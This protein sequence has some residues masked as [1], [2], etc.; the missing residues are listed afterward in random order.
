MPETDLFGVAFGLSGSIEWASRF[1]HD[2]QSVLSGYRETADTHRRFG[3]FKF[4][5]WKFV[6]WQSLMHASWKN[7][8]TTGFLV[9]ASESQAIKLISVPMIEGVKQ[10]AEIME[11]VILLK[12]KYGSFDRADLKQGDTTIKILYLS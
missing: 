4:H 8:C 6:T 11:D 10:A 7:A 9:A 12:E 1:V 5:C 2:F 3:D